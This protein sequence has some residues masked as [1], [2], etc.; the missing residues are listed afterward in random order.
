M[1]RLLILC[2]MAAAIGL[3]VTPRANAFDLLVLPDSF[4]DRT[5]VFGDGDPVY[6]SLGDLRAAHAFN[7]DFQG[8]VGG[9]APVAQESSRCFETNT[10][11]ALEPTQSAPG[12]DDE[13]VQN[14]AL[15]T[16]RP[17]PARLRL[18]SV[19][20]PSGWAFA[21]LGVVGALLMIGRKPRR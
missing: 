6:L 21:L 8:G 16:G 3:V 18:T 17:V 15:R 20:E 2:G 13:I 10:S 1:R 14:T 11:Q 12:L 19:P 4:D 7:V 9:R 5:L